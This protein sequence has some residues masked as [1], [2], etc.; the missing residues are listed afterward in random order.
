MFYY[1]EMTALGRWSPRLSH[2]DRPS[3]KT[4]SGNKRKIRNVRDVPPEMQ[5]FSLDSL[6]EIFN[7][8]EVTR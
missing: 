4:P 5:A 1:E 2:D 3:E 7:A 6:E 8:Q